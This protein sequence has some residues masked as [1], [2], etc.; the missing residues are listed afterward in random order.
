MHDFLEDTY[1]KVATKSALD[2]KRI[3]DYIIE[4]YDNFEPNWH[5]LGFIHCKLLTTDGGTLRL[6]IW[7]AQE[8]NSEE[9]VEKIH[10]HLFSLNSFVISGEIHNELF[11]VSES[12]GEDFTHRAYTVK[13][14][15]KGSYIESNNKLYNVIKSREHNVASNEY[16]TI[17]SSMFH[18]SSLACGTTALTLVATYNH[19]K[20][21]PLTFSSE[22]IVDSKLRAFSP[23]DKS[24]WRELLLDFRQGLGI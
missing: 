18:R 17:S 3:L 19:L 11:N 1:N 22:I 15:S 8:K 23:Y 20:K 12:D 2:V 13:Y 14:T 7:S 9:Q 5:A 21:D 24:K 10:D 6:H 4:S 16:Y